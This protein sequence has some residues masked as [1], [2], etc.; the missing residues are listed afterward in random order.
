MALPVR[1]SDNGGNYRYPP[2]RP[3]RNNTILAIII[4]I[5]ALFMSGIPT[6]LYNDITV[7]RHE[8]IKNYLDQR[9]QY[10]GSSDIQFK[11]MLNKVY[12]IKSS[13]ITQAMPDIQQAKILILNNYQG[14]NKLKPPRAFQDLHTETLQW[15]IQ[16][17]SAV[18][19]LEKAAISNSYNPNT[20]NIYMNEIIVTLSNI[21]PNLIQGLQ[22]EKL[23]YQINADGSLVYWLKKNY[24]S[25]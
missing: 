12:Q 13:N 15:F 24:Y 16:L 2:R 5:V 23:E 9:E 25:E 14:V 10:F 1:V 19:Y 6:K 18:E 17:N 8:K 21:Q 20:F 22:K 3:R 11:Q 7:Y 4:V